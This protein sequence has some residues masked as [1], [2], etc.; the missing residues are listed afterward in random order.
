MTLDVT[1]LLALSVL[2]AAKKNVWS[3]S[4]KKVAKWKPST[5]EYQP[6]ECTLRLTSKQK[7][8]ER[9]HCKVTL[10]FQRRTAQKMMI[11]LRI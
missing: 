9:D 5:F 1:R 2:C 6:L 4:Q 8:A 10:G 3:T 7:A 11:C